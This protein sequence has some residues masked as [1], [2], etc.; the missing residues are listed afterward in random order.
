M[1]R[2]NH[3]MD[4]TSVF[5]L[6]YLI[7]VCKDGE[8]GFQTAEKNVS[9]PKLK[10]VFLE[11]AHHFHQ[12][13]EELQNYLIQAGQTPEDQGNMTGAL[14]RGWMNIKAAVTY[15]SDYAMLSECE[16][17]QEIAMSAYTEVLEEALF[18][19]GRDLVEYHDGILKA[20]HAD[21]KRIKDNYKQQ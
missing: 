19:E 16:K 4:A 8:Q 9:D 6:N 3:K 1:F 11:K 7:K 21:V 12:M 18:T 14:Y 10:T 17:G 20:D 2:K 13:I 5:T 15:D